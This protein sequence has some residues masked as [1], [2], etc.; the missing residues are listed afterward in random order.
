MSIGQQNK[1]FLTYDQNKKLNYFDSMVQKKIGLPKHRDQIIEQIE[2]ND[3]EKELS[4]FVN[5]EN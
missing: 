1:A 2:R 5:N 3:L 4:K